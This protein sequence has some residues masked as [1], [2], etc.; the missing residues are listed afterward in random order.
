MW[1]GTCVTTG[2]LP[3]KTGWT[4]ANFFFFF[5]LLSKK[6]SKAIFVFALVLIFWEFFHLKQFK[7]IASFEVLLSATTT[8]V[9]FT[10]KHEISKD[11]TTLAGHF[12]PSKDQVLS[13]LPFSEIEWKGSFERDGIWAE[14]LFALRNVPSCG[15]LLELQQTC[16]S[17]IRLKFLLFLY[18]NFLK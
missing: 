16:S 3:I 14:F 8:T 2:I 10:D 18:Q 13:K 11:P 6:T 15:C 1:V 7:G 4:Q 9:F 5:F 17:A 12:L